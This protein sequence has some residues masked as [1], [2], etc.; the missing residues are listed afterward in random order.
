MI[1]SNLVGGLGNQMFQYACA[2]ALALDLDM[3]LRFKVDGFGAYGAH[4][5]L[6]LERVFRI[7]LE[8]AESKEFSNLVGWGRQS[9]AVRRVLGKR[10]FSWLRG[11]RFLAEPGFD[12]WPALRERAR[13]GAYLHGY[14]QSER[15]FERRAERIRADFR[16]SECLR[17]RNVGLAERIRSS[18]SISVHIRRGDYLSNPKA[19]SVHGVCTLEYYRS[20]IDALLRVCPEACVFAFSDDPQWVSQ[21]LMPHYPDLVLVDHNKGTESY[22]D[23][24]LMSM[25]RHHVV[26]NSSFSW[27]GAWLNPNPNKMVIAPARWFADGRS[28][29]DLVPDSWIRM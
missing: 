16:F 21:A 25:C 22:I 11:T 3:P 2:C 8:T 26:A 20:A 19:L 5:G 10:A 23:M 15:Y 12:F 4:N 13:F 24:R 14:W 1:V 17:G 7:K 6:E 28:A 18:A 27:W 29:Q 9:P